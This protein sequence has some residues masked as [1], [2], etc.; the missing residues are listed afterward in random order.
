MTSSMCGLSAFNGFSVKPSMMTNSPAATTLPFGLGPLPSGLYPTVTPNHLIP[1]SSVYTNNTLKYGLDSGS[2]NSSMRFAPSF[3]STASSSSMAIPSATTYSLSGSAQT[4]SNRPGQDS[5]APNVTGLSTTHQSSEMSNSRM[6]SQSNQPFMNYIRHCT[7]A[8]PVTVQW[9]LENYESADGVSLSRSA[10][11]SHYLS[12][13]LEHWLEP[14]NPASFGKLIRSIFVGLRTRRLGTRF[15]AAAKEDLLLR[16]IGVSY[17]LNTGHLN[18]TGNTGSIGQ[19][20]NLGASSLTGGFWRSWDSRS[21]SSLSRLHPRTTGGGGLSSLGP[22]GINSSSNNYDRAMSWPR[23]SSALG[24]PGPMRM[25]HG[26][27]SSFAYDQHRH[28]DVSHWSTP[29][30]EKQNSSIPERSHFGLH[31]TQ[32]LD[33]PK[34]I[35]ICEAAGLTLT[36]ADLFSSIMKSEAYETNADSSSGGVGTGTNGSGGKFTTLQLA[37]FV[38]LYESHCEQVFT[39]IIN[40]QLENLRSIWHQFWRSTDGLVSVRISL[41]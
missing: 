33:F 28:S 25:T 39:V 30:A 6:G 35:D 15:L 27:S 34:L 32:K 18:T 11:Y 41:T 19:K 2:T 13:C 24:A 12:H 20:S 22:A 23:A 3:S 37:H 40:L 7:R 1:G 29:R 36:E 14:M 4:V 5:L 16:Q 17:G 38:K 8:S 21:R 10:L 26:H 31:A 9:L